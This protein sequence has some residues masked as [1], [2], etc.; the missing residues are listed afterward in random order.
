MSDEEGVPWDLAQGIR[1]RIAVLSPPARDVLHAAAV[2]EVDVRV[3]AVIEYAE[4]IA[5]AEINR[6]T[7]EL[8]RREVRCDLDF[9][10]GDVAF[11]IYIR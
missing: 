8:L 3:A 4:L 7:A 11:N 10:F 6:A 2:F 5:E 1:Q 9:S